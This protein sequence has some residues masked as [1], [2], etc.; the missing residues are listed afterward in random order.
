MLIL[1][2]DISEELNI[3]CDLSNYR[4]VLLLIL[5]QLLMTHRDER[6]NG[7]KNHES[8]YWLV[9]RARHL[10]MNPYPW[11]PMTSRSALILSVASQMTSRG[12]P[13]STSVSTFTCSG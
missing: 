7:K 10:W 6:L 9:G 12:S 1:R 2:A 4:R 5:I 8:D 13:L 11:L 3:V